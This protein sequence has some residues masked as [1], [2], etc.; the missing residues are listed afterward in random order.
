MRIIEGHEKAVRDIAWSADGKRLA[1]AFQDR[2]IKIWNA[3]D[4]AEQ[5]VLAGHDGS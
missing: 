2:T 1:T 3:Q 5:L 4:G